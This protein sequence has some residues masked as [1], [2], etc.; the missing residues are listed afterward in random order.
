MKKF[1]SDLKELRTE[2]INF[3][4]KEMIPLTDNENK[5]YEEPEECHICQKEFCYDENEKTSLNYTKKLEITVIIL[6]NLEELL[7]AFVI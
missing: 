3:E 4:Q 7:I 1:C 5:F 6:Q 2:I